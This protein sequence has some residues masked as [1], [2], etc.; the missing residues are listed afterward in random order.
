MQRMLDR[1]E[2]GGW[3]RLS[4]GTARSDHGRRHLEAVRRTLRWADEAAHRGDY[5]EA[6]AWLETVTAIGD[7]L[8]A[9]YRLKHREWVAALGCGAEG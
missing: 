2:H 8:P 6:I 3:S 4:P 1:A 9:A 5:G 7:A